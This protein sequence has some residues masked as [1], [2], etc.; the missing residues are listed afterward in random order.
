MNTDHSPGGLGKPEAGEGRPRDRRRD[1]P[2]GYGRGDTDDPY[3]RIL[4]AARR[5]FATQGFDGTTMR[6]IAFE[7]EVNLASIRYYFDSKSGLYFRVLQQVL[8]PLGPRILWQSNRQVPPLGQVEG[9]VREFFDHVRMNP[10][11]PA[12][13]VREM[14]SGKDVSPPIAAMMKNSLPLLIAMIANGQQDGSIRAGD[15]TLLALS[16]LAQPVY[17]TL[18]R[19]ALTQVL[20]LDQED[21]AVHARTVE[22]AV[23]TIRAAL[24]HR[25]P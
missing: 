5:Q 20:G 6:E 7:A 21:P 17:L 15:T 14:A 4:R 13:M 18:T 1:P 25:S 2:K 19:R 22:H 11:M 12:L 24:E 16:T 9:V 3:D 8:G 23:T 10:D